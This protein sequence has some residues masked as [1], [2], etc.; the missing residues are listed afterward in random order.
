M[1]QPRIERRP[2]PLARLF[3]AVRAWHF[4]TKIGLAF[5]ILG[6]V[7]LLAR[8]EDPGQGVAGFS[9]VSSSSSPGTG[10]TV[11][12]HHGARSVDALG[13]DLP[14]GAVTEAIRGLAPG[15]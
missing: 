2:N 4:L 5:L 8:P 11:G 3:R 7:E 6:T 9:P 15:C 10:G 1:G 12:L 14:D 13:D